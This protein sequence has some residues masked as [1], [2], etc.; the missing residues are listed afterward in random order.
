MKTGRALL[1]MIK[2]SGNGGRGY[3]GIGV[4]GLPDEAAARVL[5]DGFGAVVPEF[6]L[7]GGGA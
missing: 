5:H 1:F 7:Q 4:G 2:K 6:Q 3:L